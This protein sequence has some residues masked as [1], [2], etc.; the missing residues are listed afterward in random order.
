[1]ATKKT[2]KTVRVE[3]SSDRHKREIASPEC[4]EAANVVTGGSSATTAERALEARRQ[5]QL[6]RAEVE[7]LAERRG[8]RFVLDPLKERSIRVSA[9]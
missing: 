2:K 4:G 3:S 7:E 6:L 1:M 9:R 8:I 5:A